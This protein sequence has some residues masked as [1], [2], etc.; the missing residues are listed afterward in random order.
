MRV[1]A[2]QHVSDSITINNLRVAEPTQT[3]CWIGLHRNHA[4]RGSQAVGSRG[5]TLK[6][7]CGRVY[8]LK[9]TKA[10][11]AT[12]HAATAAMF[13][14]CPEP[15]R[16]QLQAW[17]ESAEE[18]ELCDS[19]RVRRLLK[20]RLAWYGL[21]SVEVGSFRLLSKDVLLVDLLQVRGAVFCS[22]EVD[23]WS[24]VIKASTCEPLSRLLTSRRQ[25]TNDSRSATSL[26]VQ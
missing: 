10:G 12:G 18:F 5:V 3:T 6:D 24:G 4:R 22:V 17:S 9:A 20:C 26:L 11:F 14:H 15:S 1:P 7:A 13:N 8:M 16:R 2:K 19:S 21:R 25:P 23:R